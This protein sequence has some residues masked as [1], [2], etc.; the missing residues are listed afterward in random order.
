MMFRFVQYTTAYESLLPLVLCATSVLYQER[1]T[2]AC[3]VNSWLVIV[4]VIGSS[5]CERIGITTLCC[6]TEQAEVGVDVIGTISTWSVKLR[7]RRCQWRSTRRLK[8]RPLRCV[9]TCMHL[10]WLCGVSHVS[11]WCGC[12]RFCLCDVLRCVSLITLL[13]VLSYAW[14]SVWRYA[15]VCV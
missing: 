13:C 6:G 12:L 10:A 15:C 7:L 5:Q 11:S 2:P 8:S 9:P 3:T 1:S 4:E 14:V